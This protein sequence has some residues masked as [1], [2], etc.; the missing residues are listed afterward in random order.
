MTRPHMITGD[1]VRFTERFIHR[2]ESIYGGPT[3]ERDRC[4][5]VIGKGTLR[6]A[7]FVQWDDGEVTQCCHASNLERV[8]LPARRQT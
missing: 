7:V 8:P 4:G 2:L 5:T 6:T 3:L 1:R